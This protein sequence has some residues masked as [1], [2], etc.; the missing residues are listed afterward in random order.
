MNV[1]QIIA[2]CKDSDESAAEATQE[3]LSPE[4]LAA[5]QDGLLRPRTRI[6]AEAHLA[7]CDRCLGQLAAANRAAAGQDA[8][9]SAPASLIARAE[10]LLTPPA[11][12][13]ASPRWRWAV[14]LAAAAAV[15]LALSLALDRSPGRSSETD[16]TL[17]PQTRY[18]DREQ[19]QPAWLAPAENSVIQPPGQVFQWT[20]VPGALF[21]EVH[22]VSLDGD[23]LLR[24]RVDG[25]RWLIPASLPLEPGEEY[26]VRVDAWLS[27]AKY[28]SSEHRAFRVEGV[29]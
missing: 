29:R 24:D 25:T 6:A 5:Y 7:R 16:W 28:L 18:A 14:P 19:L 13:K 21:Y 20:E 15:L 11:P 27:D 3:C 2:L 23:L 1:R 9:A 12:A 4:R 17:A 8:E 26:F 10:A 22:L